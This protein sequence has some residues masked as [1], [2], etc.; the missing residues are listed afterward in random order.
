MRETWTGTGGSDYKNWF[1]GAISM[2][3]LGGNDNLWGNFGDDYIYGGSG[4]DQLRGWSGNDQLWGGS[5]SDNLN[6][7]T[8]NDILI[9]TD[10]WSGVFGEVDRLT[11]GSGADTFVLGNNN[12]WFYRGNAWAIITDFSRSSGDK[13][14]LSGRIQD[15]WLSSRFE[16]GAGSSS[17]R[18]GLVMRGNDIVAVLVDR[19]DTSLGIDYRYIL[20]S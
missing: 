7:E 5:G 19:P 8:G 1:G 14:Q 12:D 6:G 20:P 15:Y 3:G 10:G 13:I 16:P 11:G 2:S 18:D 9:G 17:I 4:N